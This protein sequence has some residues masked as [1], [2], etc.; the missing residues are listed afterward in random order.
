MNKKEDA[1]ITLFLKRLK[2]NRRVKIDITFKEMR[3][4]IY[5]LI[6]NDK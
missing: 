3:D 6:N 1:I 5:F 2:S 4:F